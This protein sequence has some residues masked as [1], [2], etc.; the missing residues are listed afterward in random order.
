MRYYAFRENAIWTPVNLQSS[1]TPQV[2]RGTRSLLVTIST[3]PPSC[4]LSPAHKSL[5]AGYCVVLGC[6]A[7][8]GERCPRAWRDNGPCGSQHMLYHYLYS[9]MAAWLWATSCHGTQHAYPTPLGTCRYDQMLI[10]PI[11][12]TVRANGADKVPNN[13][14]SLFTGSVKKQ[15][16]SQR[17]PCVAGEAGGSRLR[18]L[19]SLSCLPQLCCL[20]PLGLG[21]SC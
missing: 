13:S 1:L 18:C 16:L 6:S 3:F 7:V 15:P 19:C 10:S 21:E 2:L 20:S 14:K 11:P 4:C 9:S 8:P 5:G 17:S 12:I